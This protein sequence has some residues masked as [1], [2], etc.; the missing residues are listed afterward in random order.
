MDI[1]QDIKPLSIFKQ[2]TAQIIAH[3]KA[4]RRPTIITINGSAEVVVIDAETYQTMMN[5]FEYY[6]NV[7]KISQALE[8]VES[9]KAIPAERAF[10][11]FYKK[12]KI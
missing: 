9:C 4:T 7:K 10:A 2:K 1:L 6:A 11:A 12:Y 5:M 3:I 8:E